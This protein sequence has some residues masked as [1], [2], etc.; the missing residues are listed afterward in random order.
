M[1]IFVADFTDDASA[2]YLTK[3]LAFFR[4]RKGSSATDVHV[5]RSAE[6]Y[7]ER[8][9]SSGGAPPDLVI[10]SGSERHLHEVL[11][12]ERY[13][14]LFRRAV[15]VFPGR[16]KEKP[17]VLGICLGAQL[18]NHAFG[19][20]LRKRRDIL[21]V[22][23]VVRWEQENA[24]DAVIVPTSSSSKFKFCLWYLPDT[25]G[26][27][28]EPLARVQRGTDAETPVAFKHRDRPLYGVLFHPEDDDAS[29][30]GHGLL[31]RV[32]RSTRIT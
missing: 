12:D 4:E 11:R 24:T 9:K 30:D 2:K 25:L 16:K 7:D 3:I 1:R 29:G 19:G 21:C 22:P 28:L 27:G 6:E 5:V 8:V 10:L 23:R 20:T 15:R 26:R 14:R 13:R 31:E 18:L 17:T 32:L